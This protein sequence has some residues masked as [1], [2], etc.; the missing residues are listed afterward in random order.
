MPRRF[1]EEEAQ[2]I[3]ARVAE[4]QRHAAATDRGLSLAELEEAAGAAG[5]DP[6]LVAAAAAELD[7]APH[8][9][10]TFLGSP[11]EVI[12]H[13]VVA[14]PL[15]DDAWAQ[16][17]AAARRE[18]GHPGIAG[19]IG[20]LR[21]WTCFTGGQ[22]GAANN[23]T[24]TRL[25]AEPTADG[26]RITLTRSIREVVLGITIATAMQWLVAS[27]FGAIAVAGVDSNIWIPALIMMGLGTLFGAGTFVGTRV[28]QG[29]TGRQFDHLLDRLELAAQSAAPDRVPAADAPAGRLD[30]DALADDPL[31]ATG[32]HAPSQRV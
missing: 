12:R 21:E 7:A 26:T 30:L 3:F 27:F 19:Q 18:F 23:Q 16:M 1:T 22:N 4:R 10:R 5:L 6:A 14:G 32:S 11:V 17:V 15:D 29:R 9:E 2:R 13:R 24:L 28:W 8:P 31:G 20:R 25:T